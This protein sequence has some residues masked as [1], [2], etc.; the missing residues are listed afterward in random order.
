M[1]RPW[2]R[3]AYPFESSS[4]YVGHLKLPCPVDDYI[5]VLAVLQRRTR[6]RHPGQGEARLR[7]FVLHELEQLRQRDRRAL[8]HL[9]HVEPAERVLDLQERQVRDA[10][11]LR[12]RRAELHERVR[13]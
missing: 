12:L 9:V 11:H 1:Q 10:E 2:T 6:V 8:A 4:V 5:D 3:K 13:T 7:L